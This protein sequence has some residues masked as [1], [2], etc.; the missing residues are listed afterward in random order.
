MFLEAVL[1]AGLRVGLGEALAAHLAR[2]GP[3]DYF[4][5]NAYL[6]PNDEIEAHL[7]AIRLAVRDRHRVASCRGY[8]PRFLHSTG[9]L[10]KGG[11]DCGVFLQLTS[12]EPKPLAIPGQRY[13]FDVLAD[14]QAQGDFDVLV[15]RDR[16]ALWLHLSDPASGLARLRE[17]LSEL[18]P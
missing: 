13:S 7:D 9:Q 2:L 10:Q 8:G 17:L 1:K 18:R 4:S 16:R 3:G 12:D 6:D 15:E 14:A 11:P 5:L